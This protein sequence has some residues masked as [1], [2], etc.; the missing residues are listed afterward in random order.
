VS[1]FLASWVGGPG[2]VRADEGDLKPGLR[3]GLALAAL[4]FMILP[5]AV[6][7]LVLLGSLT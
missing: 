2:A 3:I 5:A 1:E 7:I 6:G 4:A